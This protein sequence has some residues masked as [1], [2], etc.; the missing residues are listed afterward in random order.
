MPTRKTTST[1]VKQS[2]KPKQTQKLTPKEPLLSSIPPRRKYEIFGIIL[3]FFG[4]VTILS[5]FTQSKGSVM[6]WWVNMVSKL[7]GWGVY[8]LPILL[9]IFGLWVL[10]GYLKTL[11]RLSSARTI[12]IFLLFLNV[13]TWF[14]IIA[15]GDFADGR[16]GI[17]GGYIGAGLK[18]GFVNLLGKSGTIVLLIAWLLIGLILVFD[19]GVETILTWVKLVSFKISQI[20]KTAIEKVQ[21]QRHKRQKSHSQLTNIEKDTS[22]SKTNLKAIPP[23]S[24][25]TRANEDRGAEEPSEPVWVLPNPDEILDP[26]IKPPDSAED[27][28]HRARVIEETLRSF[29][30]PAH[31][32]EIKR[33]PAV[34][35][36]GVEPD[37]VATR[38]G[39]TRVRVSK[40]TA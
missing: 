34:T 3:L 11:P 2:N 7:I 14:H 33:G 9:I 16:L 38:N 17:G 6:R 24:N 25:G 28:R 40:I 39:K 26:V 22:L 21:S 13:L 29:G 5:L 1:R 12:G 20:L 19:L 35:L 10:F 8:F 37:F 30:T 36:F 27:D 23:I 31:V 4:T 32:V 18:I 15:D